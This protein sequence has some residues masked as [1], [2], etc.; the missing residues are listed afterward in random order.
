MMHVGIIGGLGP[1]GTCS[2][3]GG[4]CKGEDAAAI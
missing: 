4:A 3:R 1:H 2:A